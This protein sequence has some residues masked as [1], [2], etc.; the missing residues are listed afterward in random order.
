MVSIDLTIL[1]QCRPIHYIWDRVDGNVQGHCFN[2]N[3]F[4]IGSGSANVFLNTVI[5][6]LLL[7]LL[8]RLR[9][10]LRQQ[11]ILLAIFTLTGFIVLVSIILVVVLSRVQLPDFTWNYVNAGTWSELEPCM[12]VVCACIPSL[13]PLYTTITQGI[14]NHP[15]GQGTLHVAGSSPSKRLWGS[16]KGKSGDRTFSQ[17]EEPEDSRPLGECAYG[18]SVRAGRV[19]STQ[20]EE[21]T[22]ELPDNRI[23]VQTEV[24][25]TTSDSLDY[26]DRL[27]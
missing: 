1:F 7:P 19:N 6:L 14:F 8:W 15:L 10:T 24:T 12:A 26:N 18:A 2:V 21:E 11:L 20:Q 5:F 23:N 17:L 4:F 9:T 25:L 13:R 16:S 22:M 3:D 27:Y